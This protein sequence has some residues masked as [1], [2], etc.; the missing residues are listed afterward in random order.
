MSDKHIVEING[1]KIEVDWY[2][3]PKHCDYCG[4]YFLQNFAIL[5]L[6]LG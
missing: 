2:L 4:K 6:K 3:E 5:R 1:E